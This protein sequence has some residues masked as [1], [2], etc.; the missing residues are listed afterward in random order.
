MATGALE[1][2]RVIAMTRETQPQG[3]RTPVS[4]STGI[5]YANTSNSK[6]LMS[7]QGEACPGGPGLGG[8]GTYL[9]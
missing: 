1:D 3:T 4:L 7:P 6:D 8:Q 9:L 5:T 2:L